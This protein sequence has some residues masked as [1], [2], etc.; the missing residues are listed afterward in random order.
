MKD[1]GC[2]SAKVQVGNEDILDAFY[3]K[4]II[5]LKIF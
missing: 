5:G 1:N 3:L 4:I 2:W